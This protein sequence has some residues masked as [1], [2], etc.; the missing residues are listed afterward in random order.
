MVLVAL[1]F[2]WTLFKYMSFCEG[3]C[4]VGFG[5][6]VAITILGGYYKMILV[7]INKNNVV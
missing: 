5:N 4:V 1:H 7:C 6:L 3:I 2:I